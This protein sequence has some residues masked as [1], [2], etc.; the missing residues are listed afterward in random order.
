MAVWGMVLA[1][2]MLT[3]C[4]GSQAPHSAGILLST[5]LPVQ[6][7]GQGSKEVSL[8]ASAPEMGSHLLVSVF[9][10]LPEK[11]R[12]SDRVLVLSLAMQCQRRGGRQAVY[13]TTAGRIADIAILDCGAVASD[14][15]TLKPG[16]PLYD[17]FSHKG[18]VIRVRVVASNPQVRWRL[19]EAVVGKG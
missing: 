1:V 8:P 4:G 7:Q 14:T 2:A 5:E 11:L 10:S 19:G 16:E 9:A 15:V 12:P 17:A 18:Q 6:R 3:G 13:A